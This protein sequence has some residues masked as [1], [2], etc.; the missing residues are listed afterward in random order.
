MILITGGTGTVG[1]ELVKRLARPEAPIRVMVRDRS[2]AGSVAYPG[3][4]I[5]EG[6]F[7]RIDSLDAALS[8]VDKAFLLAAPGEG[9]LHL[10]T[11]F[12]RAA[13]RS[14]LKHIVKLSALG[15]ALDSPARLLRAHAE[16]EHH[17]EETGV[18]YTH[19]RPNQFMQNFLSYRESI[20]H[21]GEFYAPMGGGH[22]SIVD[23]RDVAAVAAE[24]LTAAHAHEGKIY[25]IT[26]PESLTY[27]EMAERLTFELGKPVAYVDVPPEAA[28]AGMRQAG[29]APWMVDA[30]LELYAL[31]RID[32][33]A[34]VTDTVKHEGKKDPIAFAEFAHDYAPQLG[35]MAARLD[36]MTAGN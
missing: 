19:L 31:W 35:R 9:Q 28:G 26:G 30:L 4:E 25:G 5:V 18:P 13:G 10:E 34:K 8:G 24:V 33:A 22:A 2:K 3:V 1:R 7:D 23:V 15:A 11:N 27:A 17:I 29:M 14:N 21:R 16:S 36:N 6:D 12:I 20:V 32:E